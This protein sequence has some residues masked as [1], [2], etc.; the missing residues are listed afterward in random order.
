ML[1]IPITAV[2]SQ[3]FNATLGGQPCQLSVYTLSS[4]LYM[5]VSLNGAVVVQGIRCQ[6]NNRIVRE[7]YSGFIGDLAFTDLQGTNDPT[8]DGLGGRYLLIYL[9]ATDL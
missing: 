9:E 3:Q 7:A 6:Y 4:G 8:Y 2:P 5:D 1:N